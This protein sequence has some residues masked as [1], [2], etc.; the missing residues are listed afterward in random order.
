MV[1]ASLCAVGAELE[2]ERRDEARHSQNHRARDD[3]D[4]RLEP[5]HPPRRRRDQA[6]EIAV[7][8]GAESRV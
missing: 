2:G 5:R 1:A 4:Q 8:L 3:D 7:V 6:H